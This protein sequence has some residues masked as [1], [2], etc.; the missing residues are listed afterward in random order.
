MKI[1]ILIPVYNEKDT[2]LKILKKVENVK[3]VNIEKE[4][5]LVDDFST[6]GT[7]DILKK[8]KNHKILY[9]DKNMGKGTALRTAFKHATGDIIIIQDADLE[10]DPNDYTALI[11]PI[12][13]KKADV[14]FGSRFIKKGFKPQGKKIFYFGNVFLSLVTK[15]LYF[16]RITDMETCYK[17]FRRN[18]LNGINIRARGFEFEPEITA[19]II[20]KGYDVTEIP[21]NYHGR[22]AEEGKKLK[23][24]KEGIRALWCLI[25]YRF[26]D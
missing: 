20:K 8:I 7:R 6:D 22:T 13:D 21:V 26:V 14:V 9:H 18:V 12:I 4:I 17:V 11:K 3:L 15:L 1:S 2:L 5:I 23:P 25:K 10:Y 19:K 16:K 24:I